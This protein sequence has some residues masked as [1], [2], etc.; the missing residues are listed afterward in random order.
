VSLATRDSRAAAEPTEIRIVTGTL[1][2][3][4]RYLLREQGWDE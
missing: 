4:D 3:E 2:D 1:D